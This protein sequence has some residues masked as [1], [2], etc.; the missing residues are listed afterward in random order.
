MRPSLH[1]TRRLVELSE[2]LDL[3]SRWDDQMGGCLVSPSMSKR[4]S[5]PTLYIDNR[6]SRIDIPDEGAATIHY[7]VTNRSMSKRDGKERHSVSIDV[8]SIQSDDDSDPKKKKALPGDAKVVKTEELSELSPRMIALSIGLN[9]ANRGKFTA[10][11][12]RTGKTTAQL[13]HSKNPLTKK[14]AVFAEN[15]RHWHHGFERIDRVTRLLSRIE[16]DS[17]PRNNDGEF[18]GADTGGADPNSMAAAYGPATIKRNLMSGAVE[19][20]AGGAGAAIAAPVAKRVL[21]SARR[22]ANGF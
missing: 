6:D 18:V 13:A 3:G 19:G 8:Q 11:L 4:V 22:I 2:K 9:P 14:R 7:T 10:T 17:R 15:A 12:K 16:F 21:S 20:L 5:Y 1:I